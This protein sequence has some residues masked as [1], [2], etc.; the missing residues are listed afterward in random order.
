MS[1]REKMRLNLPLYLVLSVIFS[2]AVWSLWLPKW[3]GNIDEA[4]ASPVTSFSTAI[5][6]VNK[7]PSGAG[8]KLLYKDGVY[9]MVFVS[10]T[11]ASSPTTTCAY[12]VSDG[13]ALQA[14]KLYFTSSNNGG[15]TWDTP[16]LISSNFF[17]GAGRESTPSFSYDTRRNVYVVTYKEFGGTGDIVQSYS[18]TGASWTTV[19]VISDNG[20]GGGNYLGRDAVVAF[21]TSS[22]LRAVLAQK[23]P[24][25]VVGTTSNTGLTTTWPTSTVDSL[26][27]YYD[28]DSNSWENA[29]PLGISI[30]D[31]GVIHALY[32][33]ASSTESTYNIIY[34]SSSDEGLTWATTSISGTMSL[35]SSMLACLE[36]AINTSAIDPYTGRLSVLYYQITAIDGGLLGSGIL[37][38][39]SSLKVGQLGANG[40]WT[41]STLNTAVPLYYSMPNSL[42]A[43]PQPAGLSIPYTGTYAGAFFATSSN[44]YVVISTSTP[45]LERINTATLFNASEMSTAYNSTSK[46]LAVIYVDSSTYQMKFV[47]TALAIAELN[48]NATTTQIYPSF[49]TDASGLVTVT[50]TVSDANRETVTVYMDY[51]TDGGDTWSSSTLYS[52]TGEGGSLSTST[53][54]VTG[55]ATTDGT[56]SSV[57]QDITI[58]WNTQVD[59]SASS[60]TN[61]LLRIK[62]SDGVNDS[63]N[64]NISSVFTVDNVAPDAPS[65]LLLTPSTSSIAFS[66][67]SVTGATLYSV[68]STAMSASTTVQTVATSTSLTPNSLYIYQVKAQDLY[69]NTSSLSSVT[70]TYTDPV[71][72]TDVTAVATGQTTMSV[73]WTSTNGSGT[74]YELYNV[75]A[76]AVVGTTQS[77]SY[78]VTGLSAGTSYEFK[79]RVQYLIDSSRYTSY[80][81]TSSAVSTSAASTSSGSSDGGASVP[82]A[83]PPSVPVSQPVTPAAATSMELGLNKPVTQTVGAS[84]HTYTALSATAQ[85][86][87]LRIQSEPI[88]VNLSVGIPKEVDTNKDS[89]NDLRIT[90]SGLVQGKPKVV[91]ANL[92]DENEL[93]NAVTIRSGAYETNSRNVTLTLK[94]NAV[95]MAISNTADFEGSTFRSYSPS[96]TWDLTPG[97]GLKTVYVRLRSPQGS[98]ITVSDTIT[99]NASGMALPPPVLETKPPVTSP[100]NTYP[101]LTRTLKR[102][103]IGA[104]V[105][106]VQLELQKL[107]YF[108]KNIVANSVFGPA[109]EASVR[110]YQK[111]QKVT[112]NGQ[113]NTALYNDIL[114]QYGTPTQNSNPTSVMTPIP[115]S[116]PNLYRGTSG[117]NVL[118]VQEKLKALG[119]FP[120]NVVANSYYGPTTQSSVRA[121]QKANGISQT[122]TVGPL[123]W[124]ALSK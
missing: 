33:V 91:V 47:T 20:A 59:L 45:V 16:T 82:V 106:V 55:V 122:G 79:V 29:R 15:V 96:V 44:P 58:Y 7:V 63:P 101:A 99:L 117:A 108:P 123:T 54:R 94:S 48:A 118:W 85:S 41:T 67:G 50:T 38:T 37:S 25:M 72:V 34:A 11:S 80:S 52:A 30:D 28:S 114:I 73:S 113:V 112:I 35:V 89:I 56:L 49:A 61:V 90:Y 51:S 10:S 88:T 19:T 98:T 100:V 43:A 39:T 68:S 103:M 104:D 4:S 107:G 116:K 24:Y 32:Q 9:A 18:S 12:P 40:Q 8:N 36:C 97:N 3:L 53:G 76:G 65:S 66:W 95:Q 83:S 13:G 111:A 109:T 86:A 5:T 2:V 115:T 87:T 17:Y 42:L 21:A 26:I 120:K 92:T 22:D 75:T 121:F 64:Y 62:A 84:V 74:V 6:A 77:T 110:A 105:Q 31:T 81:D 71:V 60:T 23:G 27:G 69:S 93:K 78:S 14:C 124:G 70:S 57:S 46:E 119:Y 102:G 1:L